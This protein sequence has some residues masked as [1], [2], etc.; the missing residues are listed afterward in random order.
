MRNLYVYLEE[1]KKQFNKLGIKYGNIAS[2]EESKR[3]TK[4][5]GECKNYNNGDYYKIIITSSLVNED[6]TKDDFRLK[7]TI[8]HEIIYTVD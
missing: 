6:I 2:I 1:V 8:A 3:M 5:I 7:N 4:S